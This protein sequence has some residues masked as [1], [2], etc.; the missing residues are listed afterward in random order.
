M[1]KK[2]GWYAMS[3]YPDNHPQRECDKIVVIENTV[4]AQDEYGHMWGSYW[5][6][7]TKEQIQ[8]LLD[9]KQIAFHNG[10]YTNFISLEKPV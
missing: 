6:Q 9:G 7:I 1:Q 8:A 5:N 4:A 3:E 10:E 2:T